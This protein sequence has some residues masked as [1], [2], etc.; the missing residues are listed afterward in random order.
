MCG[1][2]M[3]GGYVVE[4]VVGGVLVCVVLVWVFVCYVVEGLVEGV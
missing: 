2:Y 4:L 3:V 1:L